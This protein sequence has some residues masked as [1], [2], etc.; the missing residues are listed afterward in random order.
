[1]P[2]RKYKRVV[3]VGTMNR[4]AEHYQTAVEYVKSGKLG[5]ICEINT[6]ACQVRESIGNPPDSAPPATVDYDVWLGPAPKRPF[7]TNRFHYT[8]RFF[9]DYGNT[10][11]GN[12]G[13]APARYSHVRE[14]SRCAA[15]RTAFPP[16]FPLLPES[17]G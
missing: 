4:S 2:A 6:W 17:T 16:A 12:N 11:L 9:W 5:K 1:M 8:W 7:N 14:S 15:W 3:Q 10:E 13:R